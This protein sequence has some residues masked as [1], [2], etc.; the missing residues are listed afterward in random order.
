MVLFLQPLPENNEP[1]WTDQIEKFVA[2]LHDVADSVI[3]PQSTKE[4]LEDLQLKLEYI[5]KGCLSISVPFATVN[6]K[7]TFLASL[8]NGNFQRS[9]QKAYFSDAFCEYISTPQNGL[10]KRDGKPLSPKEQNVLNNFL[11]KAVENLFI[12]VW[13]DLYDMLSLVDRTIGSSSL[14]ITI[15][16]TGRKE[17]KR[18]SLRELPQLDD[19]ERDLSDRLNKMFETDI[20]S[21]DKFLR[22]SY[23]G[24][25]HAYMFLIGLL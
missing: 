5:L 18:G 22:N 6:E 15:A 25:W 17:P 13:M 23:D 2:K 21:K 7:L 8:F 19:I 9:L 24:E 3:Q 16:V 11:K 12:T 1:E 10:L 4:V 14:N 20:V